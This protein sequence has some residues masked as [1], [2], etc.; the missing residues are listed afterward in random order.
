MRIFVTGASGFVGKYIMAALP[1]AVPINSIRYRKKEMAALFDNADVIIHTAAISN[2]LICEQ[3]PEESYEANVLLPV[4]IAKAAPKAKLICFSSDQVY[5]GSL[6]EGPYSE[7]MAHPISTY[8]KHKLEMEKRV[9]DIAS[10]AI[11]LRAS[12]MF[13]MNHGFIQIFSSEEQNIVIPVQYRC[14]TWVQEV[15]NNIVKT[16]YLPSG[17]YNYGSENTLPMPDF[18]KETSYIL[19]KKFSIIR[20]NAKHNL[21]INTNKIQQYGISF[22]K[23]LE[24]VQRCCTSYT[25]SSSSST[26]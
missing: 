15:A 26:N 11:M 12:W 10:D 24:A 1:S 22:S 14:I 20:G 16:F 21:W 13:D 7:N 17:V 4:E 9:L 23:S 5:N 18:M 25:S 8:A 6:F 2:T 19:Q 3:K